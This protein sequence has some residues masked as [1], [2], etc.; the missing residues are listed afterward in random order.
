VLNRHF[1]DFWGLAPR[2]QRLAINYYC[3]YI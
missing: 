3:S 2:R 1:E